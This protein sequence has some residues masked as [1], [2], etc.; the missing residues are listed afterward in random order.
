MTSAPKGPVYKKLREDEDWSLLKDPKLRTDYFDEIKYIPL[1][2]KDDWYL[3]VGGDI[4]ERYES[5]DHP[6]WGQGPTDTD[7]YL[8]ERY[9]L[10]ADVHLGPQFRFFT[11]LKSGIESGRAGGPRPTDHDLLD[12]NQ[13]FFDLNFPFGDKQ[14]IAFR[15][16]RQEMSYGS[17][18]L[19]SIREGPN[20]QQTFDGLRAMITLSRWR[21]DAFA[22]RP[23]ETDRGIFDD[24]PDH[25]RMFWGVYAVHPLQVL[26]K[27]NIDLYYLGIDRKHA[28]F[29]QG[30]GR[31]I[32]HSLGS[33]LWG[34]RGQW[35]YNYE[36]LVQFG[37]FAD[38][39][40]H[41]W[42]VASDNGYTLH[43][44][45]L[46]PRFGLKADITSGDGSKSSVDLQ[47]FNPLFPKGAYFGEIALI[48]PANHMD[49]HPSVAMK[50]AKDWLITAE[51]VFF[52][53]QSLND[54][55]YGPAV[56]LL[57]GPGSSRSRFV[58]SQPSVQ[59]EW[60]ISRHFSWTGNYTHFFS[61]AF[62]KDTKPA[63]DVN[64]FTTWVSYRF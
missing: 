31:E 6:S 3:S 15:V 29:N 20:V 53:R 60:D 52:W 42:T 48:G 26:P 27:G 39:H 30:V 23:V 36:G 41:A 28:A 40:I 14:K 2:G 62:L 37:T 54:G 64:Y 16:G 33:R 1:G 49:L 10:H 13:A 22:T 24:E 44:T 46:A 5:L 63:N 17:S 11:Q 38:G 25:T 50:I 59:A 32:R 4:R 58:G 51:S 56:N 45:R 57:R 43:A 7:G 19:I 47:T 55:I 9:M 8:L 12:L 34:A 18:R 35:D 61:G 21:V